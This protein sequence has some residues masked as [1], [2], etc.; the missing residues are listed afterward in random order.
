MIDSLREAGMEAYI[1]GGKVVVVPFGGRIIGLYP[2]SE[3]VLWTNPALSKTTDAKS[4]VS[5]DG[6][7]NLGGDRT[8][9]S[10]EIDTNIDDSATYNVQRSVDPAAYEVIERD[11]NSITIS[12]KMNVYFSRTRCFVQLSV[13][14]KITATLPDIDLSPEVSSAGYKVETR[15]HAECTLP[16]GALPGLWNLLQVKGGGRIIIPVSDKTSPRAFIGAPVF[17]SNEEQITCDVQTSDNFKFG[18]HVNTSRG[19][20]AYLRPDKGRVDL[21][22]RRFSPSP[23]SRYGDI[24]DDD[25][26]V[27]GFIHQ[28]YV[29]NGELGGFGEIEHHSPALFQGGD[30]FITD[31]CQTWAFSGPENIIE[32]I[33]SRE[34][35]VDLPSNAGG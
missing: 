28:I 13:T 24:P 20:S 18:V 30:S 5:S 21:I 12:T 23:S 34:L 9:I 3:N 15:L 25:P 17:Q 1:L 6:W 33:C 16:N 14:K 27:Q 26:S 22:I 10:P 35:S 19:V 31:E 2:E 4:F 7:M 29:D 11:D 32:D 8:W